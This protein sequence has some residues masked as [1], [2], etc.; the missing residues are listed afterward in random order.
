[1]T[2]RRGTAR[3]ASGRQR[4]RSARPPRRARGKRRLVAALALLA[5]LIAV[6][7]V[8]YGPEGHLIVGRAAAPVL[9]P[10]AGAGVA[11]LGGGEDLGELGLWADRIRSDPAYAD[12]APWHYVNIPNGETIADHVTPPEGD[13]LWAIEHF[14]A[15]LGDAGLDDRE[16]GEALR[17]LV[18]FVVDLHQPLHVGL[19]EDRGGNEIAIVYGG[20][21]INLHRFWDSQVIER[22]G[23]PQVEYTARIAGAAA[24]VVDDIVLDH[25]V[26]AGESLALR[27]TVYS[28]GVDG[29]EPAAEYL[30]V[31]SE[32]TTNRLALA[33]ARLAATLNSIFCR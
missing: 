15:R 4:W 6:D 16:R 19:A 28:F 9:C 11:R 10:R 22:A 24:A 7:A 3:Q 23:I 29:R 32:L 20:E 33:A 21:T 25:G 27:R 31:A 8:A 1:M 2:A 26:W 5:G 14:R 12:A 13:V 18:H 30:E 17:F